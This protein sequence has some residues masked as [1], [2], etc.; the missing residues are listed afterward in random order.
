MSI[1]LYPYAQYSVLIGGGP[2]VIFT[3]EIGQAH[4]AAYTLGMQNLNVSFVAIQGTT[5]YTVVFINAYG[6]KRHQEVVVT[7]NSNVQSLTFVAA[8]AIV[9]MEVFARSSAPEDTGIFTNVILQSLSQGSEANYLG[10]GKQGNRMDH[11][12]IVKF[13]A[14]KKRCCCSRCQLKLISTLPCPSATINNSSVPLSAQFFF[15]FSGVNLM[16]IFQCLSCLPF[17]PLIGQATITQ[18]ANALKAYPTFGSSTIFSLLFTDSSS[19]LIAG[20]ATIT[21]PA[22]N[23]AC[24]ALTFPITIT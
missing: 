22:A 23:P 13:K 8:Q 12:K 16:Y 1:A 19:V 20:P 3:N 2:T 21:I 9:Y 15:S 5:T 7:T 6:Q 11:C 17:L 14:P 4:F 10:E 24:P 18:G